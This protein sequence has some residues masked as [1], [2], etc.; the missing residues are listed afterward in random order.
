[1]KW[2]LRGIGALLALVVLA[3]ATLIVIDRASLPKA[4]DRQ[5]TLDRAKAYDVRIRRDEWGVPHVLG[6]TDADAAFGLA[7]AQSEDD[8]ETLQDVVLAT[9]GVLAR[10]KGAGAAPTDYVSAL[11]DVWPTVD[12]HYAELPADLRKL[13]EAYAD[14]VSVYAARHP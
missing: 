1:M 3:A 5:A 11:L 9:R 7:Y 13:M 10:S 4:P 2:I 6:R 8:F 14:G 12:A